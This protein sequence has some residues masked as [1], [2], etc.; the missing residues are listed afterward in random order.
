LEGKEK[1]VMEMREF[2]C[3]KK[4]YDEIIGWEMRK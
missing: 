2:C 4:V 1:R 3:I